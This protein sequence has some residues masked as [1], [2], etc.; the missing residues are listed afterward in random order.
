MCRDDL[1]RL[2]VPQCGGCVTHESG[3]NHFCSHALNLANAGSWQ[4]LAADC[5]QDRAGSA[6]L[7]QKF[8]WQP[9]ELLVECRQVGVKGSTSPCSRSERARCATGGWWC[10][11]ARRSCQCS[12]GSARRSAETHPGIFENA[13]H[14]KAV[15]TRSAPRGLFDPS[16][17]PRNRL[18]RIDTLWWARDPT[19]DST[20][21]QVSQ[22]EFWFTPTA[23]PDIIGG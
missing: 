20:F 5:G 10:P 19:W 23:W 1:G 15:G 14:M 16:Y 8:S 12:F 17:V 22:A 9:P 13:A 2:H 21:N 6:T 18:Y 11:R 3:E 4:Q 7:L